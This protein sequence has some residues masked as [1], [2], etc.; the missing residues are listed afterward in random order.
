VVEG[1]VVYSSRYF[2]F[3]PRV[4]VRVVKFIHRFWGRMFYFGEY[5]QLAVSLALKFSFDITRRR[6]HQLNHINGVRVSFGIVPNIES[7]RLANEPWKCC[8]ALINWL[9][10]ISYRHEKL[11]YDSFSCLL[12]WNSSRLKKSA[13]GP[14]GILCCFLPC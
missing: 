8:L 6:F 9:P 2:G 1:K 7:F 10:Q 13:V 12:H 3:T 14:S 4:A 5:C 11:L